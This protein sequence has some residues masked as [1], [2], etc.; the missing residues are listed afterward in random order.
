MTYGN[1]EEKKDLVH[2]SKPL[3]NLKRH[4]VKTNTPN[5]YNE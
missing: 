2:M 3:S 5:L 4:K 1:G